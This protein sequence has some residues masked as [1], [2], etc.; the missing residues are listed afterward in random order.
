VLKVYSKTK[1]IP[2]TNDPSANCLS[3]KNTF[4]GT[5]ELFPE[6][7][8]CSQVSLLKSPVPRGSGIQLEGSGVSKVTVPD[9]DLRV[10]IPPHLPTV[11]FFS[12]APN[13]IFCFPSLPNIDSHLLESISNLSILVWSDSL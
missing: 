1:I 11:I 6:V 10:F 3:L 13:N 8:G 9:P 12:P 4:P 5:S 2:A 7:P